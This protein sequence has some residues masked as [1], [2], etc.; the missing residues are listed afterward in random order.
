[1]TSRSLWNRFE[2]RCDLQ[3][4]ATHGSIGVDA[5][6]YMSLFQ[7]CPGSSKS[8][9]NTSHVNFVT[10]HIAICQQGNLQ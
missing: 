8:S 5:M 6:G 1:M 4:H 3:T 7:S 10:E 9:L 2:L